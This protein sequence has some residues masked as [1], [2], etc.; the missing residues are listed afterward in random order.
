MNEMAHTNFWT[1]AVA[2]GEINRFGV[3][4]MVLL[5]VGCLGGT[6]MVFGASRH[7]VTLIAVLIPTMATLS[8]CLAVA[9]MRLILLSFAAAVIIDT[10]VCLALII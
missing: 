4:S 8:T 9:P 3:I 2:F 1:R 7:L 10:I 6:T 5:V